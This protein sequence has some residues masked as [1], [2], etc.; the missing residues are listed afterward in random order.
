ME[1]PFGFA[2]TNP[3][4]KRLFES[5]Q[6]KHTNRF[7]E[8][9]KKEQLTREN[10]SSLKIQKIFFPHWSYI[11]PAEVFSHFECVMFHMTDLPF[12]RGG[13]PLQNLIAHGLKETKIS[14]FRCEK[15][16]DTGPVY[17]KKELSLEGT[18]REIFNRMVPI[19]E[20]MIDEIIEKK[21]IPQ[22]QIGEPTHFKRRTPDQGSI[23]EL[24]SLEKIYDMIRM[25]DADGYPNAF[26]DSKNFCLYF[27][28]ATF[29]NNELTARVS[30]RM[31]EK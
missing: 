20:N 26:L 30:I 12:G 19:I 7:C 22:A 27:S 14:A 8:F 18:A 23:L 3:V 10:L 6:K 4:Y 16:V 31:K 24:E 29:E 25:L 5:L 17:L 21:P 9:T 13:S 2:Y 15:G 1:P 28:D 11:I